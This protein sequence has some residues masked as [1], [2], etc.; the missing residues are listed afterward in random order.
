M[1]EI[2][3]ELLHYLIGFIIVIF[4]LWVLINT[5]NYFSKNNL[6][7]DTVLESTKPFL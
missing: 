7:I 3:F 4:L 5:H 1:K 6:S 2:L